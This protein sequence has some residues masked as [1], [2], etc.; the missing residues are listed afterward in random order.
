MLGRAGYDVVVAA[1]EH[2]APAHWSR[3]CTERL[4]VVDPRQDP[5]RFTEELE[6]LAA[7]RGVDML[8]PGSDATLLAL[9]CHGDPSRSGIWSKIQSPNAIKRALDKVALIECA[10]QIGHPGPP[11]VVCQ[12]LGQAIAAAD[13]FGY[14]V[15]LKPRRSVSEHDG[16]LLQRPGVLVRDP[17]TLERLAAELGTPCLVQ[18]REKGSIVSLGGVMVGG[19]LLAGV[20]SR[21]IRTWPVAAGSACYS[22]TIPFTQELKETA[23]DFVTSLGWEGI[24]EPELLQRPEGKLAPIDFNP[25]IYGSLALAGASGV[26]L[27]TIWCDWIRGAAQ[28]GQFAPPAFDIVGKMAM[29]GMRGG[30]YCA[31]HWGRRHRSCGRGGERFT[32]SYGP[33]THCRP[34]LGRTR[35]AGIVAG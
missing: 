3:A 15:V 8:L 4:S 14:P 31:G 19:R 33:P 12:D 18:R 13:A 27:A 5:A 22:E 20:A 2:P 34:W 26:P 23:A 24:F 32:L 21:Y 25:R 7:S 35:R 10:E 30:R 1:S 6:R 28:T 9:A 17:A 16:A 11:T 29:C